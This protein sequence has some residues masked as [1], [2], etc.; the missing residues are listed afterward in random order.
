[1]RRSA[2][3]FWAVAEMAPGIPRTQKTQAVIEAEV[4]RF[5]R[6]VRWGRGLIAGPALAAM[7]VAQ[8][9]QATVPSYDYMAWIQR[10]K[11]WYD[12]E[13]SKLVKE[14]AD[15]AKFIQNAFVAYKS[16][17][18]VNSIAQRI[19]YGNVD[20]LVEMALPKLDFTTAAYKNG[21]ISTGIIEET[22]TQISFVPS[23]GQTQDNLG[24][25]LRYGGPQVASQLQRQPAN[26]AS[27]GRKVAEQI[28]DALLNPEGD[29]TITS[30]DL[31]SGTTLNVR[32]PEVWVQLANAD[33]T[34]AWIFSQ[35]RYGVR[36]EYYDNASVVQAVRE[37]AK[38]DKSA[39]ASAAYER[40]IDLQRIA[41]ASGES[42]YGNSAYQSAVD[43]YY[44]ASRLDNDQRQKGSVVANDTA[45]KLR[46]IDEDAKAN[47]EVVG[48][49]KITILAQQNRNE[50]MN[51]NLKEIGNKYKSKSVPDGLSLTDF[52]TKNPGESMAGQMGVLLKQLQVG[53]AS[54]QTLGEIL[55]LLAQRQAK[56]AIKEIQDAASKKAGEVKQALAVSPKAAANAAETA[57]QK[58]EAAASEAIPALKGVQNVLF[59]PG[60]AEADGRPGPS[61]I[62]R[63]KAGDNPD[64][65]VTKA[66]RAH[67]DS[68]KGRLKNEVDQFRKDLSVGLSGAAIGSQGFL[69]QTLFAFSGAVRMAMGGDFKLEDEANAWKAAGTRLSRAQAGGGTISGIGSDTGLSD[70]ELKPLGTDEYLDCL[71]PTI[72]KALSD[73]GSQNSLP[74]PPTPPIPPPSPAPQPAQASTATAPRQDT[75]SN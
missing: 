67:L 3:Y 73:D 11:L 42:L 21:D 1:M 59:V 71:D 58:A 17:K 6:G 15:T 51:S 43:D 25:L 29:V 65:E 75:A 63:F 62:V 50:A 44:R 66:R 28:K 53:Q 60:F 40:M 22:R 18:M 56:E 14:H 31:D 8:Q 12:T 13:A 19:R 36:P 34:A 4:S 49:M 45:T 64:G 54:Q 39:E 46:M 47:Q 61:R 20:F 72:Q 57:R 37:K 35:N 38:A 24:W 7:L 9:A 26:L 55:K 69:S 23:N 70:S 68:T 10:A 41:A 33:A 5:V 32:S 2:D 74:Q 27:I 30:L 48:G 16:Y 52:L